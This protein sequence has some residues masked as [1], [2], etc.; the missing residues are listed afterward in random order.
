MQD[1]SRL[2]AVFSRPS[3]NN[4]V[5]STSAP[6]AS[7][8]AVLHRQIRHDFPAIVRGEG[9]Y[10]VL[11]DGRRILDA[12]GG[13]AVACIG[14]GDGRVADAAMAQMRSAAYCATIFYTNTACEQLCRYL[15]D[16]TGG[17]MARAYIVCSGSEA[18]EAAMKLARQYYLEKA[19]T[20]PH[21]TRFIARNQSYHGITLG[22]LAVGGHKTR[23]Q[24]FEPLMPTNVS[25]VSPCFAYR[26]KT[27]HVSDAAYVARL[28]AE[29][30]AEFQ[31]V[32]P[33]TVCAFVAEPVVGAVC[34]LHFVPSF[35][36]TCCTDHFQLL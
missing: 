33:D 21:R 7:T 3:A 25:R 2:E 11:D 4:D 26:G 12:S 27:A 6:P 17:H 35:S 31:R 22:A 18:M 8:S 34:T 36:C 32:G 13:A 16:S 20:E 5:V 28:A 10:L 24:L 23:R 19:Q 14:H 15:V 29:L 1:T 30:D 9:S